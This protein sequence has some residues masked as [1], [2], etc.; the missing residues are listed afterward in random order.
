[1]CIYGLTVYLECP[2]DVRKTRTPYI[3]I[4]F[5]ILFLYIFQ[6][7]SDAYELFQLLYLAR[8]VP[9]INGFR[10][11]MDHSWWAIACISAGTSINWIADALLVCTSP[12]FVYRSSQRL[13][14][15]YTD[16]GSS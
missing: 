12:Y 10:Q 13:D 4:S 16:V 9:N 5:I 8:V 3:F 15:S 2:Q 14:I 6:E 1:M 11:Q 7:F